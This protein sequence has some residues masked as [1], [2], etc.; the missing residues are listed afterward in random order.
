MLSPSTEEVGCFQLAVAVNRGMGLE[1]LTHAVVKPGGVGR[2]GQQGG[3][4]DAWVGLDG[5]RGP[6]K[7]G[8]ALPDGHAV[9]QADAAD[10]ARA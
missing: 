9:E 4:S 10:E 3:A 6:A 7:K 5:T 8:A 1:G 2:W